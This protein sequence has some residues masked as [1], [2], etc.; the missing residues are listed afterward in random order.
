MEPRTHPGRSKWPRCGQRLW[1]RIARL[2][3]CVGVIAS[4]VGV[5]GLSHATTAQAD[6]LGQSIVNEAAQWAGTQY[7]WDGGNQNG[8]TR[9]TADP[10]DGGYTCAAGT[11]GFDCTGLTMYAVYQATG[12]QVLLSHNPEQATS[13]PS[14]ARTIIPANDPGALQPG[15]IV[16]FGGTL[17]DND[18]AGIYAGVVNGRPSFWSAVT[19]GIGVKL[20]TMAWEEAANPFVGAIRFSAS[21]GGGGSGGAGTSNGGSP[22][23]GVQ[24]GRCVDV[25][26]GSTTPGAQVQLWDCNGG[27][28]QQWLYNAGQLQVYGTPTMCLDAEA[29]TLGSNGTIVQIWPCDGGSNQ[30][31]VVESDGTLRNAASGRCLDATN[32]G[33]ANGTLLQLWDCNGGAQQQ[34]TVE[35][36]NGGSPI[37]PSGAS[38]THGSGGSGPSVTQCKVPNLSRLT[39]AAAR[40]ALQ[41]ARCSVGTV[42]RAKHVARGYVLRVTQQSAV[43]GSKHRAGYAVNIRLEP[44]RKR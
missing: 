36:S 16:Y 8:P 23:K 31:W 24:S 37:N 32:A 18:H 21:G 6:T 4:V 30:Q 28:Q 15:D 40:A 13:D 20:E 12:G 7:C 3:A 29:Q 9:G 10:T 27:S 39:L 19:E 5:L 26:Q 11:T 22:I 14:A 2:T 17:D 38:G 43:Y 42:R 41:R 1:T 25:P 34:W 33:T 44:S 35:T